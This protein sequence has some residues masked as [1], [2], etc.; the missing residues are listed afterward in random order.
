VAR[1]QIDVS[2]GTTGVAMYHDGGESECAE[3]FV[4]A[5]DS[6]FD[7]C[8][9][10]VDCAMNKQM[11]VPLASPTTL[12]LEQM[13]PHH[14][15]AVNMAKLLLRTETPQNIEAVEGLENILWSIINNQN[16]QIHQFRNL[17]GSVGETAEQ[18][19]AA[20]G[21]RKPLLD[22]RKIVGGGANTP[23]APGATCTPTETNLCM[24]LDP[25]ASETGYYNFKGYTGSSPD[26]QV[27]I[28]KTYTFDQSDPT[29]WYHPVGF[30]YEPDGAHGSTWGGPALDEVE[31]A[32][33]LQYLIDGMVPDCDD[34]GDTGLDCYEPE[35]FY[36]RD[37]WKGKVY[38][39]ELTITQGM[40]ERSKGGV[41]Y[42]FC[43]IHSK[44]SGKIRIMTADGNPFMSTPP[45]M[46]LPL[47][48]PVAR[49]QIDVSCGTTGVAMYTYGMP[50]ACSKDFL[51]GNMT[52]PVVTG[53][54]AQFAQ[55]LQGVDCVMNQGMYQESTPEH[56]SPIVT[57]Q[58]QMIPHHLNAINMAKL[59]LKEGGEA[60]KLRA[61]EDEESDDATL[62][63]LLWDII[64][65][66]NYQVHQFRNNLMANA[67]NA[68]I[69]PGEVCT[70]GAKCAEGYTCMCTGSSGGH[71]R[72]N[73]LFASIP[74]TH[75][76]CM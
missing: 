47:Y 39:A 31:N 54:D 30:A 20:D 60:F 13:V 58:E 21:S 12:F 63:A 24:S 57:F 59:L 16:Y 44:M 32:G 40:A 25:F 7:H 71:S 29:N 34:A 18:C 38:T 46:E 70:Q 68:G 8:L 49:D 66:Q 28:G 64:N 35:F 27:T 2:C 50:K 19:I 14:A 33:E 5:A 1:D 37:H 51:C 17:L 11:R 42:Y 48:S 65:V 41:I 53:G 23:T 55:C 45:T 9:Q 3:R 69:A 6:T 72:R 56:H 52:D 67:G 36:P 76:K 73:L 22:Q 15:N 74:N 75:C 61:A 4:P 43:H 62:Y 26:I 10:A